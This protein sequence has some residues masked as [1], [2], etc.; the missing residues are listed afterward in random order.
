[1]NTGVRPHLWWHQLQFQRRNKER[2]WNISTLAVATCCPWFCVS[3][4]L[5]SCWNIALHSILIIIFVFGGTSC[6]IAVVHTTATITNIYICCISL[7]LYF[8]SRRRSNDGISSNETRKEFLMFCVMHCIKQ[9][10]Y[11]LSVWWMMECLVRSIVCF[12]ASD[13]LL[14]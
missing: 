12:C 8:F 2:S 3:E 9:L 6:F 5:A 10:I 7:Y 14:S 4:K 11:I 13:C 1:M